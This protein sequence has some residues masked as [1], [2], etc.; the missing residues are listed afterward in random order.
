MRQKSKGERKTGEK[1]VIINEGERK[2]IFF[3]IKY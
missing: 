2:F 1:A 3:K